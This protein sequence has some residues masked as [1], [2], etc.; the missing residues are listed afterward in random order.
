METGIFTD[1]R[2]S[3][4]LLRESGYRASHNK[5]Y[6]G[7]FTQGS[8][9][10]S[11]RGSFEEGL[12]DAPQ[13]LSYLRLPA[14]V[15][16][17]TQRNPKSKVGT[18]IPGVVGQHPTLKEEIINL[19]YIWRLTLAADGEALDMENCQI[20]DYERTL[21]LRTGELT[22]RFVWDTTS[23]AR[24]SLCYRRMVDLDSKRTAL[25]E[26]AVDCLSGAAT[27]DVRAG[28]DAD[29]TTNG[30]DHF[31]RVVCGE[32][33][34]GFSS[35]EVDT[36][37]C[38]VRM[39]S[40]AWRDGCPMKVVATEPRAVDAVDTMRLRKGE[41]VRLTKMTAVATDRDTDFSP[42]Q[43]SEFLTNQTVA[44]DAIWDNNRRAWAQKWTLC[45]VQIEGDDKL[46]LALRFSVYHL[47]RA[48][49]EHDARVSICPKGHAGE[50]YFGR[51]FWDADIFLLPFFLYTNPA[52]ARNLT[53][54][55]YH[56]LEGAKQNAENYRYRG[57]RY[58]LESST[59]GDEQ[60]AAWNYADHEIHTPADV[61][62][63]LWHY[64]TATG[65]EDFLARYAF[66]I[67]LETA[68]YWES[69]VW[70]TPDGR[71]CLNGVM[72]PDEYV[73]LAD[74]D[75]YTNMIVQ[76]ALR[77][78]ARTYALLRG[79]AGF[80]AMSARLQT[81]DTEI[82]RFS[83]IA[84]RLVVLYDEKRT[85]HLQCEGFE[86]LEDIDFSA[87]W[88]DRSRPFGHFVTQERNYR[89]KALKQADVLQAI[90]MMPHQF[91]PRQMEAAYD[92]YEPITT[93]D[94]SLSPGV[95]ALIASWLGREADVRRYMDM[96][97]AVDLDPARRGAEEG[98]H[99]ANGAN[100]WQLAVFGFAGVP[101]SM[102]SEEL[103]LTPHLPSFLSC[104]SFPLCWKNKQYHVVVTQRSCQVTE[105]K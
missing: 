68:R 34:S 41:S 83:D 11:A 3:C 102:A 44:I 58:A 2:Q 55:R 28:L 7:L 89:S 53:L 56:T 9:Y 35:V 80:A 70:K 84:D 37:T 72:G 10:L 81:D 86:D 52:A 47:I 85:L 12:Q 100:L 76:F 19:P 73:M 77:T 88:T 98:I 62:Y 49:A 6:E 29:V 20:S 63:A 69:R 18:F 91:T 105:V 36:G 39:L 93:H 1:T 64:Y 32:T 24:L 104:V 95:H 99:I 13:N 26:V 66:E 31:Q 46:Q 60:C 87:V 16:L 82:K 54:F 65:D 92:Y 15:T 75:A 5:Y 57:A 50:A 27:L 22:R 42:E 90:A 51:Y 25:Q 59:F 48:N 23:G 43:L 8:G 78:T 74:N 17:E 79:R 21:D 14:N 103:V 4:Y 38:H 97:I 96:C 33:A 40:A 61:V 30:H 94:S 45:D 67:M 71:F 101:A